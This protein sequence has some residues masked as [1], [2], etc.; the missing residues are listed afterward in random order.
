MLAI[1]NSKSERKWILC[2]RQTRYGGD[3]YS[4][5]SET[6]VDS[7]FTYEDADDRKDD[8]FAVHWNVSR[9]MSIGSSR[10]AHHPILPSPGH[11]SRQNL[12]WVMLLVASQHYAHKFNFTIV[13]HTAYRIDQ[14][15]TAWI[16][17]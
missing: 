11:S 12:L 6:V 10:P 15:I 5:Q 8:N 16:F 13:M 3:S 17:L 4:D 9:G 7:S 14:Q 2:D 1:Q